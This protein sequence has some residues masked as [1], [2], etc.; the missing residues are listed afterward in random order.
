MNIQ[1]LNIYSCVI[2]FILLYMYTII[3]IL[4][5][6]KIMF[7]VFMHMI[8]QN[9]RALRKKHSHG[10]ALVRHKRLAIT[11]WTSHWAQASCAG[12]GPTD[13]YV[14]VEKLPWFWDFTRLLPW[15]NHGEILCD[16]CHDLIMGGFYVMCKVIPVFRL[17]SIHGKILHK[18]HMQN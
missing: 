16:F 4:F 13:V 5:F 9:G 18:V 2:M 6:Q 1:N 14:K 12:N 15:V 10:D 17:V 3:I 8:G 11:S 7:C